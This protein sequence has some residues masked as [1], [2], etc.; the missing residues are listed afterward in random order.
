VPEILL[1]NLFAQ[2]QME[3]VFGINMVAL[4]DGQPRLLSLKD[5]LD[6]FLRHRREVVTR[7]TVYDL[8][9]ARERGHVLEGLAVALANIDEIIAAIKASPSPAEARVALVSRVWNSGAV[10]QML[11]R[12]GGISTRPEGESPPLG[13]VT[14]GYRLTEVQ[15]QAI[16]DMRL[17]RLTGLEQEKVIAEYEELLA[18]IRDLSDILAR[19]ERLLEVIRN[20]LEAIRDSYSD[21][22]R[23]E[24]ISTHED[25]T[26]ED[27]IS[28]EEVVV[29][30]SHGGYAK[31]QP[32][33]DY[34]AQRRGG[35][36]KAATIVKDEDFVDRLFVANTHDTLLC[37]SDRGKLY[38]LKVY[39]LPQA[40]RGSRGKPIVNL[41]PLQEGERIS[42]MLPIK[43][44]EES[45]FVFMAT[46][47][48]TVKKTSLA[49]FSRPRASGIIA[50][51]LEPG[52]RLVGVAITDGS[53]DILLFTTAGKAIR[54]VEDEVRPM[55][56]EA[57]G[58]RGI[59]LAE[60]QRV[61]AL[62]VAEPGYILTAS[63]NGFG[64]LTPLEEFPT[65][66]RGGQGVIA[67]QITDRNGRMVGAL[68]VSMDDEVM[69]MSQSG[70]LVRTPVKEI[71]VVGR[72]TQGVRL[73]RLEEGDQLSGLDRIAGEP[74]GGDAASEG[75][76]GEADD[77]GTS[78]GEPTG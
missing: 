33:S 68:Q 11:A 69:L 10:P 17:H 20:E 29:T 6:A 42:A 28:P 44:F 16:L 63:E 22:R 32:V 55:G 75:D 25:L 30:L 72:N 24:I 38:W 26:L 7:R 14:G 73:I 31:A 40:S 54:F 57:A 66:G 59:K 13:I 56:R 35:R 23:T 43:E 34:Q 9:K 4:V 53:K 12:A 77:S 27:L 41:L 8:R 52:D 3:Q 62:I 46:S 71:S 78:S 39:Q 19:P 15:A 45:K 49:L 21:K 50:V 47:L 51:A 70:V 76:D 64:K 60:E 37:F 67:L 61:N 18:L 1:N 2:T 5:M 36:G 58:V 74:G 48:G 65:H